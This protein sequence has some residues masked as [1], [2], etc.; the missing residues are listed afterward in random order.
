M[1]H[2][3]KSYNDFTAQFRQELEEKVLSFGKSVRFKFNISNDDPHPDNKGKKVWPFIYTLDPA[4]FRVVDK[5]EKREGHQKM[6]YV[7]MVKDVNDEGVPVSFH[8]VKVT[9]SKQGVL[10]FDLS[11]QDD[12][13]MV[14]YLLL[15][16][17][18]KNGDFADATKLQMF[19]R[20]D[21]KQLSTDKRKERTAKFNALKVAEEMSEAQVVQFADAMLWDST[22]DIDILK[23]RVEEMAESNPDFFNDL[24]AGKNLE[25]QALIKR[26]MDKK[27]IS[28]DPAEYRFV[29]LSNNQP[30]AILQPS[31]DKN[32]VQALAEY[33][34]G[35]GN[36]ADETLKKVKSLIK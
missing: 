9:E 3:V 14:M 6:K 4:T 1:L 19:E 25:Y 21:E 34:I 32:E 8:K 17:K 20:I 24:V 30:L 36:K 22:E 10:F 27:V 7:G 31:T 23:N 5:H 28:F 33:F 18:L 15:H 16:P 29:W 11:N 12:F 35:G 13:G 2:Q 26:A